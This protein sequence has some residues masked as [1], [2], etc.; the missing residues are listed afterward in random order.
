MSDVPP[1]DT[2]DQLR[3]QVQELSG[4]LTATEERRNLREELT[5]SQRNVRE[6][7][8]EIDHLKQEQEEL[9]AQLAR[10]TQAQGEQ[11]AKHLQERDVLRLKYWELAERIVT[12]TVKIIHPSNLQ[13]TV[14]P[15]PQPEVE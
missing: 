2:I 6:L 3:A 11:D 7:S 12:K 14:K 9:Q 1:A 10:I 15:E 13:V 8:I 4:Y 5:K